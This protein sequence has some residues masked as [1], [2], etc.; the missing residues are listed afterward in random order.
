MSASVWWSEGELLNDF[1]GRISS[2]LKFLMLISAGI[3]ISKCKSGRS[4]KWV[5]IGFLSVSVV[6]LAGL[7][8]GV[9]SARSRRRYHLAS[10]NFRECSQTVDARVPDVRLGK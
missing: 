2:H 6:L 7:L 5:E 1:G 4:I 8:G 10:F 3:A 9:L